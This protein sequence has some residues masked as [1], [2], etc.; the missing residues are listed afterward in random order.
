M[1][2]PTPDG[3]MSKLRGFWAGRRMVIIAGVALTGIALHL[4]LRYG[5]QSE[6]RRTRSRCGSFWHSGG[7]LSSTNC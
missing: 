4:I 6:A 2:T 5:V 1:K 3:P 7:F